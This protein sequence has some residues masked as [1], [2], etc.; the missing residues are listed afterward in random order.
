MA[1]ACHGMAWHGH[2][3]AWHDHWKTMIQG[4]FR[5]HIHPFVR[6]EIAV[7]STP[8]YIKNYQKLPISRPSG[9]YVK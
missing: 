4:C 1:M 3:M 6:Q 2:A 8:K 9:Q 5:T 7:R